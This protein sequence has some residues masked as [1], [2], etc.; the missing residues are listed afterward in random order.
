MQ[1]GYITPSYLRPFTTILSTTK[2][3]LLPLIN[4]VVQKPDLASIALVLVIL[5]LSLKLFNMLW[6]AVMFWVRLA[7]RLAF[8]GGGLLVVLWLVNR[9]VDG[10]MEDVEYWS[11]IWKGEYSYW[12]TQA[13]STKL[14]RD[15]GSTRKSGWR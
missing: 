13:E 10:A 1:N 9:G 12:K 15:G 6:Q 14:M 7:T 5:F 3:Y 8:W 2:A 11:R 4:H